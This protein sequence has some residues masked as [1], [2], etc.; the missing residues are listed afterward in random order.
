VVTS[1]AGSA[2]VFAIQTITF[3]GV[4]SGGTF[5]LSFGSNTSSAITWSPDA[6]TL[7][8]NIQTA[9][10]TI[11]GGGKTQVSV[12][13]SVALV[14]VSSLAVGTH[15][16]SASYSGDGNFNGNNGALAN[17]SVGK[18]ATNAAVTASGQVVYGQAVTF[19]ATISAVPPAGAT[20]SG[21]VNFVIDGDSKDYPTLTL[22]G[23]G[24][25]TATLSVSTLTAGNHSIDV[26][27]NGNSN[28]AT[29]TSPALNYTVNQDASTTV[30]SSSGPTVYGQAVVFTA[31][32]SPVL[33]GAG[34]PTGAVTFAVDGVAQGVATLNG[35]K[36][37]LSD[38]SLSV[39]TNH[40]V[41]AVYSGDGNFQA[42]D[43]TAAPL[44]QVVSKSTTKTT[45]TTDSSAVTG[46]L[47][48]LTA[49]VGAVAPGAG[50]PSGTVTFTVDG[51]NLTTTAAVSNSGVAT[52]LDSGLN[53]GTHTISATYTGDSNFY[54]SGSGSVSVTVSKANTTT[55]VTGPGTTVFGQLATFVAT[56]SP[57]LPGGGVPTGTVT[58]VI[59][60]ANQP[61]SVFLNNGLATLVTK[62]FA[63]GGH[64]IGAIYAGDSNYVGSNDTGTPANVTVTKSASTTTV[65]SAGASVFGQPVTF[66]AAITATAP[67]SGTPTG[68]VTFAIDGI[69][70]APPLTLSGGQATLVYSALGAG[71]H[72]ITA[73][74]TGDG[75][76]SGGNNTTAPYLQT[77]NAASTTTTVTSSGAV[78]YG[79]PVTLFA[80]V[81]PVSPG[82]GTPTG[83]VTFAADGVNLT[84]A[85]TLNSSGVAAFVD[86]TLAVGTRQIT[87]SYAGDG[88]DFAPSNSATFNENVGQDI[89]KTAVTSSSV[90]SVYGQTVTFSATI[91]AAAP[92]GG[93]PTGFVTFA[94]DGAHQSPA[95]LIQSG[96]ATFSANV[97]AVGARSIT[98][99]YG[100]DPNFFAS[101]NIASPLTQNVSQSA[102]TTHVTTSPNPAGASTP[103]TFTAV[104]TPVAPGGGVPTGSVTFIVD[105]ATLPNTVTLSGGTAILVDSA[106]SV[107]LHQIAANYSG[108]SNFTASNGTA[109]PAEAVGK[110]IST[111]T[112]TTAGPSSYGQ[113]VTFTAALAPLPPASGTPTGSVTFAVDGVPVLPAALLTGGIATYVDSGLSTGAHQITASY[114]GDSNFFGSNDIGSPWIQNVTRAASKTSVGTSAATAV[115]GQSVTLTATISPVAPA[116]TAPTGLVTF[117]I[118]GQTQSPNA[119]LSGGQ[120]TFVVGTLNAG[121]HSVAA[122]YLGDGNYFGSDDT[123]SPT[124]LSIG[125]AGSKTAVSTSGTT[126]YGQPATFSATISSATPGLGTPTGSVTFAVDGVSQTPAATLAGGIATFTDST[127]IVGNHRITAIYAGDVNFGPSDNSL[128]PAIQA[129]NKADT[130][131]AVSTSGA[132]IYGQPVTFSATVAATAPGAGSPS[133]SVTFAVDGVNQV[134]GTLSGGVAT[135]SYSALTAG[136]HNITATYAGDSNFNGSDDNTSPVLQAVGQTQTSTT[137]TASA[138]P[139]G[140]GQAVT[141]SASITPTA[142][143]GGI[144]TGTVT[145]TIDGNPATPAA[146]VNAVGIATYATSSLSMTTHTV[147][148]AY[149]GDSNFFAS[150]SATLNEAIL[151]AT[152]TA[153]T[154]TS[155]TSVFGQPVTF[156]ATVSAVVSANGTPTG[157]LT[158]A[159]DNV[160][161]APVALVSGIATFATSSIPAGSHSITVTYGG[162]NITFAG[163]TAAL[164]QLVNRASTTTTLTVQPSSATFGQAVSLMAVV[165][166]V[167]P[168]AGTPTG[169]VTFAIDGVGQGPVTLSGGV[170]TLTLTNLNTGSHTIIATYNDDSNFAGSGSGSSNF[171]VAQAPTSTSISAS[172]PAVYGQSVTFTANV[173]STVVGA[174]TP[175]GTLQFQVDGVNRGQPVTL[176]GSGQALLSLTSL[177]GGAHTITANF[178]NNTNFAA[179][180]TSTGYTMGQDSTA[181]SVIASTGSSAAFGQPVTFTATISNNSTALVPTGNVQFVVDGVS[182]GAATALNGSGQASVVLASLPVGPHAITVTY[183]GNANFAPSDNT[184]AP[185][186]FNV[187]QTG[188]NTTVSVTPN[189]SAPG[190]TAKFSA[191]VTALPPGGGTPTGTVTFYA[192]GNAIGTGTLSATGVATFATKTIAIGTYTITAGYNGTA[193]YAAST[194]NGISDRI[195]IPTS[196]R[197]TAS[198]NPSTINKPVTFTAT[199]SRALAT[200]TVTF[201]I[202]GTTQVTVAVT[203][204]RARLTLN[205]L[206]LGRHSIR[207][208][209]SGDTTFNGSSAAMTQTVLRVVQRRL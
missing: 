164:T 129:V 203:S 94:F 148:A 114:T 81:A 82:A 49:S 91:T 5:T 87:A 75:N 24:P 61:T 209:Y 157:S 43:N 158:F 202:D 58:F 45:V 34:T 84:P 37:T 197:L 127:L 125:Q 100:G 96:V 155:S 41:T 138:N 9:L 124:T 55:T 31:T 86:T 98:A 8:A 140:F 64:T 85:A 167:A 120:A 97:L 19:T 187:S 116:V 42:S 161:Q 128:T 65:T 160:N 156:S 121:N 15:T 206:T 113:P 182:Q 146:T 117:V 144:A 112:V 134:S 14:S 36:A 22:I 90:N 18:G 59:D 53:T 141:F 168:G 56:I 38:S 74:Y 109:A 83:L 40:Q 13:P 4:V 188:T 92:G 159:I 68:Q 170:A 200:G 126:V 131:T 147:S 52:F 46:Q 7:Q 93:A 103:V 150:S 191:T 151:N 11:V 195:A 72:S 47:L 196:T 175:S 165:A 50:V 44:T 2:G 99:I 39:A 62:T 108:D 73:T 25:T 110:A 107:G 199:L 162:D 26:V 173:V 1:T 189:P 154:S 104:V 171:T 57:V 115:F 48:T 198:A 181:V 118:D 192:N 101:S 60:N 16:I 30:V 21:T 166:P 163:S 70:Q 190:Q 186:S 51:A 136:N 152:T 88:L 69:G 10:D 201:I 179:S 79:Q 32:I 204:G 193:N 12:T 35:G 71:T 119:L 130:S 23:S 20:P 27:Y 28:L 135:A 180:S 132:T 123:T 80:T 67:G 29:T 149:S 207:A 183:A 139:G 172:G 63:V 137:L 176:N 194:S 122:I 95:A 133:G 77:V 106:L 143:G 174:A 6:A 205:N 185:F 54:G 153:V 177:S 169:T 142:P 89:T 111:T 178:L 3:A 105:G 66:T 76:F 184:S 78:V 17:Y 145:F 33:P 208:V 102:T